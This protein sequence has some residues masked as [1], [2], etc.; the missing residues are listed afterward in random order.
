MGGMMKSDSLQQK[1]LFRPNNADV[2]VLEAIRS[3][4]SFSLASDLDFQP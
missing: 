3:L 1:R 4:A 2:A